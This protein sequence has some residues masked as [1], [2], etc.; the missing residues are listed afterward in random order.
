MT[1]L[2]A[3]IAKL[4]VDAN[5]F[6]WGR[7][8]LNRLFRLAARYLGVHI[9]VVRTRE[10]DGDPEYPCKLEG[11]TYRAIEIDELYAAVMDPDLALSRESVDAALARGDVIFGAF[12]GLRLVSYVWRAKESAPH[13]NNIWVRV[14]SPYCYAYRSYTRPSHRGHH[15][16]PGV[17]LCS[18]AGMLQRGYRYR[19]GYVEISNWASLAMGKYMD[20]R[21]IGRAGYL[22]WFGRFI[23][24]RTRDVRAIGFEFFDR[25]SMDSV[26]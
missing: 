17:L 15:I 7:S 18:D 24:F 11:I 21:V 22:R 6:G 26:N 10:M 5:R 4:Q 19:A 3:K 23:P 14:R 8:L 20:T 2:S 13:H 12:D 1:K 16:S 9:H 25:S